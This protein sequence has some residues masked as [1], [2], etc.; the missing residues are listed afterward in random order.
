MHVSGFLRL[1]GLIN[2]AIWFG[3]GLFFAAGILPAIFSN[4]MRGVFHETAA[5]PY[6]SG[7]VA[8]LLFRRFFILQ[9]V[10]GAIALLQLLAEKTYQGKPFPRIDGGLVMVLL[11]LGLTGGFWLQPKMEGLR[12]TRYFG[13]TPE[14]K[15]Q[16]R[17]SFGLWHGL[18]QATNMLILGGLLAHLVRMSRPVGPARYGMFYQ[19]P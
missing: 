15:E 4:E 5:D 6:Y 18:S 17:H 14:L 16:A 19:I 10:C 12:E 11:A 3:A 13:A 7:A 2:A 1:V 8:M 9:Y